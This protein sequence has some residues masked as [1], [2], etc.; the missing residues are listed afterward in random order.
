MLY[1]VAKTIVV[2]C[3]KNTSSSKCADQNNLLGGQRIHKSL[4]KSTESDE[5]NTFFQG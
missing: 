4:Q 1:P 2:A 3:S 5:N